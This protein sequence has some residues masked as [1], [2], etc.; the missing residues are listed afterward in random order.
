MI[1]PS[2]VRLWHTARTRERYSHSKP[3]STISHITPSKNKVLLSSI[4][5]KGLPGMPEL[6]I[7]RRLGKLG[8]L[9]FS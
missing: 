1:V 9:V 4:R 8:A 2:V 3:R 6:L 7:G 5:L